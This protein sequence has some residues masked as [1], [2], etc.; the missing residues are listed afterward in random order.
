M[1]NSPFMI[2][3]LVHPEA[4][5]PTRATAGDAGMDVY[6][7]EPFGIAP[8]GNQKVS[9]GWR[10]EIPEG[11]VL[12]VFNKSGHAVKLGLDKGAEVIDSGYRGEVHIHLFN[13]SDEWVEFMAGDKIAQ[14]LLMPVWSGLPVEGK[15]NMNTERGSG[16]FGS[17]GIR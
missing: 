14:V 6:T 5:M 2:V 10:C 3:E 13:H 11:W 9:L 4:K 7:P 8:R 1:N 12:L 15:V 17:T 16:G